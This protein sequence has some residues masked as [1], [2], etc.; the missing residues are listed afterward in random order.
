M[1]D[2]ASAADGKSRSR[3]VVVAAF[4]ACFCLFGFRS[5]F[6]ILQGPM[7]QDLGW[8]GTMLSTGY[9]LMMSIYAVTAYFSGR[10]VDKSGTRPAYFIASIMCALGMVLTSF[11]TSFHL[12]LFCYGFFAGVGTGMLWVSSTTSCRKWFVGDK[13]STMWGIAFAGAPIAQVILTLFMKP[14]LAQSPSMWRLVMRIMGVFFLV[15]LLVAAFVAQKNP[16]AYGLKAFGNIPEKDPN[17]PKP[18]DFTVAEAF[19]TR[20]MWCDIVALL[21][22]MIGE[23]LIW[24]QIVMYWTNSLGIEAGTASNMYIVIGACGIFTMPILGKVADRL[25]TKTGSEPVARR[26]VL[27]A[28]P[29]VAAVACISLLFNTKDMLWLGVVCCVL[30]SLYW[31]VEP[32]GAAGYAGSV[33]GNKYFG[34]VWGLA[35]LICMGIGPAVGSFMGGYLGT[36]FGYDASVKFALGGFII[37]IIAAC[38]LPKKVDPPVTTRE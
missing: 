15:A 22:S 8:D 25:V 20:A 36:N 17:A 6:S 3:K 31:A 35:T 1:V 14:L 10:V 16:D 19:K 27:I 26:M 23:F 9:S 13:Y 4:L 33:F 7:G 5:T 29:S 24:S 34:K 30:F 38:L 11:M 28:G 18:H 37:S 21:G 2:A 12:Y 32:G